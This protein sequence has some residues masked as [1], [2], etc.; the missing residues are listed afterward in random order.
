MNT[1]IYSHRLLQIMD[2]IVAAD[3]FITIS[4]IAKKLHVSNRT[5]IRELKDTE[6]I[7]SRFQ[8]T[9]TSKKGFG[10]KLIGEARLRDEFASYIKTSLKN[11]I[12]NS[13]E[14]RRERL[15]LECLQQ[16]KIDKLSYFA[17]LFDVS[18]GTISNDLKSI[19]EWLHSQN[20]SIKRGQ[21]A[22]LELCGSEDDIH[23]AKA[24]FLHDQ[25]V[26][27]NVEDYI[28]NNTRFD[29]L[30]YFRRCSDDE[31][32]I[33]NLLNED[34]LFSVIHTLKDV[35]VILLNNITRSSYLGLIIHLTIAIDRIKRGEAIEMATEIFQKLKRDPLFPI[36]KE[37]AHYFEIS[38]NIE[39]PEEEVVYIL[40]HLKGT[41]LRVPLQDSTEL[42]DVENEHDCKDIVERLILNF[43][44]LIDYDYTDDEDLF[45]GLMAHLKPAL[46]RISYNLS[47]RNPL[48]EQIKEQYSDLFFLTKDACKF[49]KN[50]KGNCIN[51]HEIGYLTLH[52]GAAVERYKA[53]I[54]NENK[55]RIG[56]VCTSGVGISVLL[57]ST[58]RSSF[59][60]LGE[61]C[62][63]SIEE[64]SE[65]SMM[66]NFDA[67]VTT[68]T[69]EHTSIPVIQVNP[70]LEEEDFHNLTNLFNQIK[71]EKR[72]KHNKTFK[73]EEPKESIDNH[74]LDSARLIQFMFPLTKGQ[75]LH[76]VVRILDEPSSVR[77]ECIHAILEREKL[78][79]VILADK[80]FVLYHA[81]LSAIHKPYIVFFRFNNYA[82]MSDNKVKICL[83]LMI[84]IPKPAKKIERITLGNISYRILQDDLLLTKIRTGKEQEII[85]YLKDARKENTFL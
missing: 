19:E 81:S 71:T 7:F 12:A 27:E 3:D 84:L 52:F 78:G 36:S 25:L 61:V 38:Q 20:L 56:V 58:I 79:E 13:P 64:L 29:E 33:M 73:H 76:N 43:S 8:V 50:T 1:C 24:N 54:Q 55:L 4:E 11:Q 34:I 5:I 23:R 18:E 60:Q 26:K 45:T 85:A 51:D 22:G 75:I 65:R 44:E 6:Y 28:Y 80:E 68:L 72:V 49:I 30:E 59:H 67:I 31:N 66:E 41:R 9:L 57:V 37:F 70:L 14:S 16:R 47:I 63:L 48:L 77:K 42:E 46:N 83:G 39:F 35:S 15:L 82:Q 17:Y 32:S 53:E 62:A 40:M 69:I 74:I 10:Y 2:S 21:M